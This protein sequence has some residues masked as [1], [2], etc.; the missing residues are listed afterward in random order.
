M[1]VVS[2]CFG[3]IATCLFAVAIYPGTP[4][5]CAKQHCQDTEVIEHYQQSLERL[6]GGRPSK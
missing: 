5:P 6:H 4:P 2:F 1:A 3:V